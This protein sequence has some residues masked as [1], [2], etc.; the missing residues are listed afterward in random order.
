MGLYG[1]DTIKKACAEEQAVGVERRPLV[2]AARGTDS[3]TR[4][5]EKP[6]DVAHPEV[7]RPA[8][9]PGPLIVEL[10]A[11]NALVRYLERKFRRH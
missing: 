11:M 2:P 5:V 7:Q 1:P 3:E 6:V 9:D 8:A 4:C 10:E